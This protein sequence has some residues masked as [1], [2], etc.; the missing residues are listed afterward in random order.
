MKNTICVTGLAGKYSEKIAQIL[1]DELKSF[2]ANIIK[3]LEFDIVD[4]KNTIMVCGI[5][6]YKDLVSK[7]LKENNMHDKS[8]E[9]IEKVALSYSY[10]EAFE[11][12]RKEA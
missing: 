10:D 12:S 9:M 1:A 3:M 8:R 2:Y 11:H 5:N 4:I 6:Y 7:K